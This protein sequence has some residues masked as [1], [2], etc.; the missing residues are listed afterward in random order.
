MAMHSWSSWCFTGVFRTRAAARANV[1]ELQDTREPP[2][3]AGGN[4]PIGELQLTFGHAFLEQL[5]LHRRVPDAGSGAGE[6]LR[7]PRHAGAAAGSWRER[8]DRG[9]AADVWPCIPGAAGASPACSG[10]GQRRGRTS[11]SSK[12]RGSRRRQLAGTG[13]SGSCS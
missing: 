11:A 1:C 8:A 3:A 6:R 9:A 5:V 12:T 10:R 2:Q 7:A 13:R 4:G